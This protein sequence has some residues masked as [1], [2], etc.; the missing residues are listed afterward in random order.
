INRKDLVDVVALLLDHPIAD[1]DAEAIDAG[2][3]G[4]L[5]ADDWGLYRTLQLNLERARAALDGLDVDAAL[6]LRR[7]AQLWDAIE[8]QPKSLRWRVRARVGD[9]LPWYELPEETRH[10]DPS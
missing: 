9:R 5:T 6:V 2:Y 4:G 3:L 10:D 8:A 1:H 7:L